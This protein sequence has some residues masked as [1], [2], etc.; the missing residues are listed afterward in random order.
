M[1]KKEKNS[2]STIGAVKHDDSAVQ[3]P[4]SGPD[5]AAGIDGCGTVNLSDY[6]DSGFGFSTG[7]VEDQKC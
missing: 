3:L 7:N 4:A 6:L 2:N 1:G 5:C